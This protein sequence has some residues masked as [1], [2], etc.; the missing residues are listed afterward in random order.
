MISVGSENGYKKN[1]LLKIKKQ[2]KQKKLRKLVNNLRNLA[3]EEIKG[4]SELKIKIFK[5]EKEQKKK[6]EFIIVAPIFGLQ[7][8]S[9]DFKKSNSKSNLSN[10]VNS[11]ED[12]TVSTVYDDKE[13]LK[14]VDSS[15]FSDD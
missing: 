10:I 4:F 8:Y 5:E 7:H 2:T 11:V 14:Q 6:L 15:D 9:E 13:E 1:L 3:L 12:N